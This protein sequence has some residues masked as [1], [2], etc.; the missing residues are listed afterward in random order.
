MVS[1]KPREDRSH[2]NGEFKYYRLTE[3]GAESN[4]SRKSFEME[5]D[6]WSHLVGVMWLSD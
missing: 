5:A 1:S 4:W 3:A 2:R 6:D